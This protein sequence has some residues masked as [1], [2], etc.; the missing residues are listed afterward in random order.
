M[1]FSYA[2]IVVSGMIFNMRE[3]SLNSSK[4]QNKNVALQTTILILSMASELTKPLTTRNKCP[5]HQEL[6]DI[7]ENEL[8]CRVRGVK[9]TSFPGAECTA[10]TC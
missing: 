7:K 4:F 5:L 3:T 6:C 8:P 1:S 9:N 2:D 10:P